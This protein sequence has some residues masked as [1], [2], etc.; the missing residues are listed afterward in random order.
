MWIM[1]G[2]FS[3]AGLIRWFKLHAYWAGPLYWSVKWSW[4]CCI[5]SI[6]L[7]PAI[8]QGFYW[9]GVAYRWLL[10][11]GTGSKFSSHIVRDAGIGWYW[12]VVLV[13]FDYDGSTS[14]VYIERFRYLRR[15][16]KINVVAILLLQTWLCHV[17]S[18]WQL[19]GIWSLRQM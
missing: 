6:V 10:Q 1:H 11:L 4:C 2:L 16:Q 7:G 17:P 12:L 3:F 8:P 14:L 5:P 13:G 15:W 19:L 9:P 18:C